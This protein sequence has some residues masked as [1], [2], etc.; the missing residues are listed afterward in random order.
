MFYEQVKLKKYKTNS[1]TTYFVKNILFLFGGG[2]IPPNGNC[3]SIP[4]VAQTTR[5]IPGDPT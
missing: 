3:L 1:L 2:Q 4:V 5:A